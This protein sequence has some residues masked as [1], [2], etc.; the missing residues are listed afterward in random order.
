MTARFLIRPTAIA[1][2]QIRHEARWWRNNRIKAPYLF[3]DELRRAF[4]LL[5]SHPEIGATASDSDLTGVRRILLSATQHY[6][7][8]RVVEHEQTIEV[9]A[10][11]STSRGSAPLH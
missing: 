6:L 3:R 8:Y 11:W 7:Y 4:K 9:L 10:V 1:A 5:A 2:E